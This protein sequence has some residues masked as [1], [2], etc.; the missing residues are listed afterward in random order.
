MAPR[1]TVLMPVRNG[2]KF[3][4]AAIES[5]TRQSFQD[6]ELIIVDDGSTDAT[7]SLLEQASKQDTR[8]RV[9][10]S[11]R[12]GIAGALETGRVIARAPY[13]ARM[14]ADDI[15]LHH[16]LALQVEYLD[17]H[18]SVVA[19]GGQVR[20]INEGGVALAPLRFPVTP[21]DCRAY[22]A[23]GAPF[24][25]PAVTMRRDVLQAVGGYRRLFEPAED[26]DLWFRLSRIGDLSNLKEE[27]LHYRR[28]AATVTARR[29]EANARA[30]AL[31]RLTHVHGETV[32]PPDWHTLH[33]SDTEWSAIETALPTHF[34]LEARASYLQALSLNGG[35]TE[36]E[37]WEHL[38]G[39]LPDLFRRSRIACQTDKVAF[40][41]VRAAYQ[42]ARSTEP[43]RALIPLLLGLRHAPIATCREIA[44][45]LWV[46]LKAEHLSRAGASVDASPLHAPV[47]TSE[48]KT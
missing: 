29:A 15:A 24:C 31:A 38:M 22:I 12:A 30:A 43:H 3:L 9:V 25:H 44:N 45:S 36:P 17:C 33:S 35:I 20:I 42:K 47:D 13:I 11:A 18:P 40:M 5:I 2:E 19:V 1:V 34:R 16:R 28:H 6:F 27:V 7:P 32:L 8:I 23:Y 10:T 26:L 37:A 21:P 41:V 46:R 48:Q 14:D 39:S 4:A